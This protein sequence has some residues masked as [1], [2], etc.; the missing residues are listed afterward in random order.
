M[1]HHTQ[2]AILISIFLIP[3]K[4]L[5]SDFVSR[6][7]N[8]QQMR[9]DRRATGASQDSIA[10]LD[11]TAFVVV[12]IQLSEGD[13]ISLSWSDLG[14]NFV[15]TVE[16]TDSLM[17]RIW[18]RTAPATAEEARKATEAAAKQRRP[19]PRPKPTPRKPA[20][21]D[22]R[23][24][25]GESWGLRCLYPWITIDPQLLNGIMRDKMPML[26]G[27][28]PSSYRTWRERQTS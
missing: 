11:P 15:Y 13:G 25:P 20:P 17:T 12:D 14:S 2:K 1:T 24:K 16:L 26:P 28:P 3:L 22:F 8:A 21:K 10:R 23:G 27:C 9:S 7:D 19:P 18:E 4:L 5:A 6:A